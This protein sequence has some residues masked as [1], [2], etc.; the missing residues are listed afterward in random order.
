MMTKLVLAGL[1]AAAMLAGSGVPAGAQAFC[2]G[3]RLAGGGCSMGAF[4]DALRGRAI[5]YVQWQAS[6]TSPPQA[7]VTDRFLA[8]REMK[9]YI[10]AQ[11]ASGNYPYYNYNYYRSQQAGPYYG[12]GGTAPLPQSAV[13][14]PASVGVAFQAA[15]GVTPGT[16]PASL[17]QLS[18]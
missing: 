12:A 15:P 7:P 16:T 2:G 3:S 8:Q 18:R 13:G 5:A 1:A 4:S 6:Y 14:A 10:L 17:I 9:R 11:T